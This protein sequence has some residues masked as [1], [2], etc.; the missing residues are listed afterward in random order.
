MPDIRATVEGWIRDWWAREGRGQVVDEL[1]AW[2]LVADRA[3]GTIPAASLPASV[4]QSG[5]AAGG[6]LTGTYPDPTLGTSGVAAAT[7]GDATHV[8]QIAVDAKGRVTSASDV[9]IS[10]SGSGGASPAT[11][12]GRLTLTTA[13][14]ITTADVTAATTLYFTPY[15]GCQIGTYSGSAWSVNAFVEKS[16]SLAGL[17][18]NTPHDVFI[19][20]G[21][22]ALEVVAW[23]N[24]TTRA[25]ALALQDGIY[26]KSGAATRR[27]LG[28]ICTTATIGQCEDSVLR[29]FVWNAYNRVPR[30]MRCIDTTDTWAYAVTAWRQAR[31]DAANKVEY[32][33]G[34]SEEPVWAQA[35]AAVQVVS[36]IAGS[37]GVGVDSTTTNSAQ[38]L[39]DVA[40]SATVALQASARYDGWPGVG[41]HYLAWL[42]YRR[43]GTVTFLGD[44]GIADQQSGMV[45][46]VVA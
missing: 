42:E 40:A 34:L 7:Y 45:A 32:V 41:Y 18:A 6:D 21:T 24:A 20:D 25:T 30:P 39:H 27:Y 35:M 19:V 2:P 12:Q 5:D 33:Q 17:A 15:R 28:T 4:I 46:S 36:G 37:V 9:A 22:L 10:A 23:M 38:L 43:A 11:C 16:L 44:G 13:T 31:A 14:P 1:R 8:P 29:R 3:V 26:V